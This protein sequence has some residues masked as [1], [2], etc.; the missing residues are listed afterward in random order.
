MEITKN[1]VIEYTH[2]N[3]YIGAAMIE[4]I[5]ICEPEEKYGKVVDKCET[6]KYPYGVVCLSDHHWCYFNQINKV[7]SKPQ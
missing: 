5:E 6:S 4:S 2:S 1:S 7:L 3:G